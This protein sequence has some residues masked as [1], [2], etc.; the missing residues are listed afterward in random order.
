VESRPYRIPFT[1]ARAFQIMEKMEGKLDQH[2]LVA[3]RPV[4][5]GAY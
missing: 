1:H 5:L 4:T 2:L 3:F